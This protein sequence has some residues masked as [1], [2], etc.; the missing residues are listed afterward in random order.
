MKV[1]VLGTGSLARF[2]ARAFLADP[3]VDWLGIAST[4][5]DRA[6]RAATEAAAHAFGTTDEILRLV[7]DA[8][9]ISS[10]TADHPAQLSACI[11]LGV[12]VLCE[13]PLAATL[14]ASEAAVSAADRASV[15]IQVGFQRRFDAGFAAAFQRVRSGQIGNLYSVRLT[16]HDHH[17]APERYFP[18]RGSVFRDLH[19]HDFDLARWL[20]DDEVEEVTAIGA[21]RTDYEYLASYADPDVTG[22]LLRMRGGIPVQIS[23]AQHDPAG[24]DVRAELFGSQDS[25]AV[26]FDSRMALTRVPSDNGGPPPA[27]RHTGFLDRF[28]QAFREETRAF[29]DVVTGL[30]ANPCPGSEAVEALRVAIAAEQSYRERRTVRVTDTV[31]LA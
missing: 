14:A 28:E 8:V 18:G 24:H 5:R 7:P 2:R 16:S 26:G 23:G 11:E 1:A 29:L 4:D 20:T 3:R 30:R 25:L 10:A 9:V 22:I 31:A 12:P 15:T 13:K 17:P 27:G 6:A 21:T 19:V